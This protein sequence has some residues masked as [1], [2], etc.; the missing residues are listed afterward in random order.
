MLEGMRE[1]CRK[2]VGMLKGMRE[3]MLEGSDRQFVTAGEWALASDEI[4]WVLQ[5]RRQKNGETRG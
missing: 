3:G 4:Q 2:G 5:H 1:G